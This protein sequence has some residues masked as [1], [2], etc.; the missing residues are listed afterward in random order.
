MPFFMLCHANG[1]GSNVGPY[2][3]ANLETDSKLKQK[4]E[5]GQSSP[6]GKSTDDGKNLEVNICLHQ[7]LSNL[8]IA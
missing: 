4:F 6:E 2:G 7:F 8:I 3:A 1:K 5:Y